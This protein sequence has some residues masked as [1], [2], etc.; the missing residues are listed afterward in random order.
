MESKKPKIFIGSSV[1][2]LRIARAIQENLTSDALCKIW[3]QGIFELSGNALDNLLKATLKCNYAIFVFQPDDLTKI[4]NKEYKTVRDNLIF[5][6]GL[7]ISRFGK[8]RVFFLIPKDEKKLHLPTDLSGIEPGHYEIQEKEEDLLATLGPFCNK[9]RRQIK[10]MVE[11]QTETIKKGEIDSA[12]KSTLKTTQINNQK[13]EEETNKSKKI[14]YGV[15]VDNFNNYT[16]SIAPTVFLSYRIAKAFPGIRGL[17][18]FNN[19]KEALDRL[20]L[21]LKTPLSFEKTLGDGVS[22]NPIWWSRG[23]SDMDIGK[24]NRVS[25]TKCLM[26]FEEL[27]IDKIAVYHSNIYWQSLVYVEV[28][29][30]ESIGL[31]SQTQE[32]INRMID[33]FG[34]AC[35]EYGLYDNIPVSRPCYDDGAAVIDGKIVDISDAE[36]RVRFLS[37]YNLFNILSNQL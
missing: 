30:E 7:F 12:D 21:L 33:N 15:S 1:E 20:E 14:E 6:L 16:I 25:E 19:P 23:Y 27:E 26:D 24:F 8:E 36:L 31:Y 4:R 3:D 28:K 2:S 5:E 35:E 13:K 17:H 18:W 22:S 34:Y 32:D 37:K 9:I 29:G 11:T 10:K